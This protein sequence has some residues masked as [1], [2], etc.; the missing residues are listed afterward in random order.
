MRIPRAVVF[1]L[2]DQDP[3]RSGPA[4]APRTRE[5]RGHAYMQ[6][7]AEHNQE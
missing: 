5:G 6:D 4:H 2:H 3:P 7:H 1:C